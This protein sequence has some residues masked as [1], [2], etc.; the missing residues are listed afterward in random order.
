[1]RPKYNFNKLL[2]FV[3]AFIVMTNEFNNIVINQYIRYAVA[4]FW[5][6]IC[7]FSC[8][9]GNKS[10]RKSNIMFQLKKLLCPF[11]FFATYTVLIWL[12]TGQAEIKNYTRLLSTI[13]YLTLGYGFAGAGVLLYGNKAIDS[14]FYS[15]CTSYLFGS[16]IPV[17]LKFTIADIIVFLKSTISGVNTDITNYMEVH[18][19]TFAMGL[20]L[21]YYLFIEPSDEKKH[22]TKIVLCVLSIFLGLKR[23]ELLALF[24]VIGAYIL[25]LKRAKTMKYRSSFFTIAFLSVILLY[26]WIVFDGTLLRLATLYGIDF[27][28]RLAY[29]DYARSY[30][31][32]SPWFPGLGYT[33]FSKMWQ[34]MYFAG[35]RIGGY[36]IAASLHSD[37]LVMF[38]EVGFWGVIFWVFY[39]FKY[40]TMTFHKRYGIL[41][42]ECF[43][44]LTIYMFLLYFT[45][46]TSTYTITQ[47]V[48]FA[49]PVA[50]SETRVSE[51]RK[52]FMPYEAG[53]KEQKNE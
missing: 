39:Y 46:N 41:V 45:D 24:A 43:L 13:L 26:I 7:F 37:I 33:F 21:L 35:T 19:L 14:L 15:G 31:N 38:I 2:Y 34:E 8:Q 17:L 49:I 28:H 12:F 25:L 18:D 6:I 29:Y 52:K 42:S 10:I 53:M 47:L 16:I 30:Y 44:L 5:T 36:G 48:Y 27:K 3:S 40:L 9:K 22:R 20:F 23:I 1:M 32:F 4:A 51:F 50:T 11:I